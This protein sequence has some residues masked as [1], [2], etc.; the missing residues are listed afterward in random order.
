MY[1]N[2]EH[3]LPR[4]QPE[5]E[6]IASTAILQLVEVL[7]RRMH[8]LHSFMLLRH[9]HVVAESWWSPYRPE[10]PHLMFS[11]SKSFTSTAV[12]IAVAEDRLSIDEPV[13][14]FFPDDRPSEVNDFLINMTVRHLLTMTSGH[15]VDTWPYQIA[16][17][18]GNWIKAFL[19]VP[20][21]HPPGTHFL[22]NTGTTYILSAIVQK[23]TGMKLID[24]L[25][26]RLF[27]PLGIQKA[28]WQ[29]S[30]QA[31]AV[32]GYGLS[33]TTEDLAR[34]GQL[35]L[36]KGRWEDRQILPEAWVKDAT[37]AQ[38]LG[39]NPNEQSDW[40]QGYGY[41]FWRCRHGAYQASG[42]FGQCCIIM[43][44]QDAVV[45]FTGGIDVL[46]VQQLLDL[47]WKMLLP[48]FEADQPT[49]DAVAQDASAKKLSSLTLAPVHNSLAL[50]LLPR[51]TK[52]TYEVDAN[53]LS[54]AS[55]T[56]DFTQSEC[57]VTF[58]TPTGEETLRCGYGE[59]RQ[60]QTNLFNRL[61][62]P[63]LSDYHKLVFVSGGWANEDC[64][65]MVFRLIE[66]PFFLQP[67]LSFHRQ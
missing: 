10:Y 29:E 13:L 28:T 57:V 53:E 31:I 2:V 7:D 33:I 15:D 60:D 25:Q 19:N 39:S 59:W 21:V 20:V 50:S 12:G 45:V 22:Y 63:W 44:Q 32:G 43:P 14:S 35:Y 5:R 37:L 4:S 30:P 38:V 40:T 3:A 56:L 1:T 51:F 27:D 9:G 67:C 49:E 46:E 26:T 6:G 11:V 24:Y 62:G 55:I 47:V 48:A 8:E 54:I 65:S 52:R 64:F 23:I 18:D 34:F 61:N 58:K 16:R 17:S 42:V 41:Q 36:Q 66:T